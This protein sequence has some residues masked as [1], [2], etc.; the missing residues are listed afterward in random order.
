MRKMREVKA[1]KEVKVTSFLTESQK[2][3]NTDA[4]TQI[5]WKEMKEYELDTKTQ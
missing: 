1:P 3:L 2:T 4:S 5:R